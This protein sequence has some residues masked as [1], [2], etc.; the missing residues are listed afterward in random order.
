MFNIFSTWFLNDIYLPH[1]DM[2]EFTILCKCLPFRISL[3]AGWTPRGI[4]IKEE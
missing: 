2:K 3:L 1:T 4:T